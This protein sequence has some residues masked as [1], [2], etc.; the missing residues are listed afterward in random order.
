MKHIVNNNNALNGGNS[1][2]KDSNKY[3]NEINEH[4]YNYEKDY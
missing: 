4:I 2:R 1:E 3:Y